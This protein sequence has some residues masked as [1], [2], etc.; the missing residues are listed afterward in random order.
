MSGP[1]AQ[2]NIFGK[3]SDPRTTMTARRVDC[4]LTNHMM[5]LTNTMTAHNQV[6]FVLLTSKYSLRCN[7]TSNQLAF[8]SSSSS[9]I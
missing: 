7:L 8:N 3:V 9:V 2:H 5:K 1:K 4:I 6:N